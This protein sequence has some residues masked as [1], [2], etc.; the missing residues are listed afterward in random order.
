MKTKEEKF[1][2][3][4]TLLKQ[5]NSEKKAGLIGDECT[6]IQKQLEELLDIKIKLIN[7]PNII[8]D[9]NGEIVNTALNNQ[10]SKNE[11]EIESSS[12]KILTSLSWNISEFS[13]LSNIKS[14]PFF[15]LFYIGLNQNDGHSIQLRGIS[16]NFGKKKVTFTISENIYE[17]FSKL[18]EQLAINKSKFVENKIQEFI[19]LNS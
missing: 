13:H 17:K 2:E 8:V 19:K 4:R 7:S 16:Y 6:I 11:D 10:L 9:D 15:Y 14:Y 5:K 1:E 12:N 3:I 18:S